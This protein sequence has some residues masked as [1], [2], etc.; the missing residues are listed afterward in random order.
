MASTRFI[1]HPTSHGNDTIP[2]D[3]DAPN[4][5]AYSSVSVLLLAMIF[6]LRM[7]VFQGVAAEQYHACA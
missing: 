7:C 1:A 6:C 4:A 3:S 2:F 5:A